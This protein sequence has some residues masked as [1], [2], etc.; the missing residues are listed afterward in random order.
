MYVFVCIMVDDFEVVFHHEGKFVSDR[1]LVYEGEIIPCLLTY[2]CGATMW[3]S[4]C[5][6]V[7]QL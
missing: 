1:K 2:I 6:G 4:V 3:F 7:K 5:V